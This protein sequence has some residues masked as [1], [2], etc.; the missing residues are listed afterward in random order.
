MSTTVASSS[1]RISPVSSTG[2]GN[3]ETLGRITGYV[4]NERREKRSE[5][6]RHKRERERGKK[7][8]CLKERTCELERKQVGRDEKRSTHREGKWSRKRKKE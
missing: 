3:V 8:Q 6:E 1:N 2:E 5:V 7:T 4:S